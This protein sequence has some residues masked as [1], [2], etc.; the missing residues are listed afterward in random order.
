MTYGNDYDKQVCLLYRQ[1]WS[2]SIIFK[3]KKYRKGVTST[4]ASQNKSRKCRSRGD[5][6]TLWILIWHLYLMRI[7]IRTGEGWSRILFQFVLYKNFQR[8][9][10]FLIW[11]QKN[12]RLKQNGMRVT[13]ELTGSSI[14]HPGFEHI[15]Q[16]SM[17]LGGKEWGAWRGGWGVQRG[18]LLPG[19]SIIFWI[20]PVVL[21]ILKYNFSLLWKKLLR[22]SYQIFSTNTTLNSLN[23]GRETNQ[24]PCL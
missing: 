8:S 15:T 5:K 9:I 17:G 22:F 7:V 24:F 11:N 10:F 12:V 23:A 20:R 6:P 1:G 3:G 2:E 14:Q 16:K 13:R 21:V 19:S 18:T 4:F